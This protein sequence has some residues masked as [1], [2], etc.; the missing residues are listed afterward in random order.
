MHR[1]QIFLITLSLAILSFA[2]PHDTAAPAPVGIPKTGLNC[3]TD[4]EPLHTLTH[5]MIQDTMTK[6]ANILQ[7][8]F[9]TNKYT[10]GTYV[11]FPAE[12]N[13][14]TFMSQ[15]WPTFVGA[16][17]CDVNQK[18]DPNLDHKLLYYMP[19]W[20]P[21]T[22][23]PDLTGNK[24]SPDYP[25]IPPTTD[26]VVFTPVYE[27]YHPTYQ[28]QFC[29]VLTNSDVDQ[30]NGKQ[31]LFTNPDPTRQGPQLNTNPSGYRQCNVNDLWKAFEGPPR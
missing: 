18:L 9:G 22:T 6:G 19:Q 27:G 24:P 1:C 28:M 23:Q 13:Q 2:V 4:K 30:D 31:A 29:G 21:G 17:G 25:G 11:Y 14:Q 10:N 12:F 3:H 7:K 20:Y 8:S 5:D 15:T 26:I 16:D